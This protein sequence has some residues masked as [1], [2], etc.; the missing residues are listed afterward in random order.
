ME[1]LKSAGMDFKSQKGTFSEK[2]N[3]A[4]LRL[5]LGLAGHT[6][7]DTLLFGAKVL[8]SPRN[9]TRVNRSDIENNIVDGKT[10]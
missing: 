8:S 7:G 3:A 1:L 9:L 10:S 6:I 2:V 5:D 4:N